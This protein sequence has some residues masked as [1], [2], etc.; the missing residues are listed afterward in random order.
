[1]NCERPAQLNPELTFAHDRQG[2]RCWQSLLRE[3]GPPYELDE[4]NDCGCPAAWVGGQRPHSPRRNDLRSGLMT[5]ADGTAWVGVVAR[6]GPI[7][8][9]V[10]ASLHTDLLRGPQPEDVVAEGRIV[11]LGRCLTVIDLAMRSGGEEGQLVAAARIT[12]A[13]P[14]EARASRDHREDYG[15]R[16][17]WPGLSRVFVSGLNN[18]PSAAYISYGA[19]GPSGP[20]MVAFGGAGPEDGFTCY[21]PFVGPNYGGCRWGDYSMVW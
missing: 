1:V 11:R 21:A 18:Y 20:V 17:L 16:R 19:S 13:I 8:W 4:S 7:V 14:A 5:R 10:S 3:L 9:V 15:R 12:S 2:L 6:I